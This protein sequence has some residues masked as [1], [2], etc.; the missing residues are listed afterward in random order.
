MT[1]L[2]YHTHR[3]HPW[4]GLSVGDDDLKVVNVYVEMVPDDEVKYEVCKETGFLMVDR[5]QKFSSQ[6][7]MVYGFIP[8]TYCGDRV[9]AL[10][11]QAQ[12]GDGDPL[13]ICVIS[14]RRVQRTDILLRAKIVGGLHM[15]DG[16]EADD[17]IIAVLEGDHAWGHANDIDE[18][19]RDLIERLR[20][21][22]LTY[23]MVP[24]G[25]ADEVSVDLVYG[26]E[27]ARAVLQASMDDY[28]DLIGE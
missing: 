20:H 11:E 25:S 18:I 13:D 4:H 14:E 5:P 24:G 15:V 3:P 6:L 8:R 1:K 7:P 22:F 9:G 17:K 27:K 26:A 16:G 21:Y 19:P 2:N 23:K 12:E 10:S 28:Q